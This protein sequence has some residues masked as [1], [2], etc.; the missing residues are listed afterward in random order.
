MDVALRCVALRCVA[1]EQV[2]SS[3]D[4]TLMHPANQLPFRNGD[5]VEMVCQAS[6]V[7]SDQYLLRRL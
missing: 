4:M 1:L 2:T 7:Q 6:S 3:P 5:L